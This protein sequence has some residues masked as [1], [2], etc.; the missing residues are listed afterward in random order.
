MNSA[1]TPGSSTVIPVLGSPRSR[2]GSNG[3]DFRTADTASVTRDR[4]FTH[5]NEAGDNRFERVN[6]VNSVR[7]VASECSVHSNQSLSPQAG[8]G[9]GAGARE[10]STNDATDPGSASVITLVDDSI[11]IEIEPITTNTDDKTQVDTTKVLINA[12]LLTVGVLDTLISNANNN[13]DSE[14]Y[15]VALSCAGYASINLMTEASKPVLRHIG[16][17]YNRSQKNINKV[18]G[19]IKDMTHAASSVYFPMAKVGSFLAET[20]LNKVS[21]QST[22]SVRQGAKAAG[23]VVGLLADY[24]TGMTLSGYAWAARGINAVRSSIPG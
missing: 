6:S 16:N 10:V 8:A 2:A 20:A 5:H 18:V 23:A 4:D 3:S 9:I 14:R 11:R 13:P 17:V 19:Q 15:L 7:S 21:P 12:G 1:I 22:N 24:A